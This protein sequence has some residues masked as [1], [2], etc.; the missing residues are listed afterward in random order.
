MMAQHEYRS[1]SHCERAGLGG[2]ILIG[3]NGMDL[4]DGQDGKGDAASGSCEI[5]VHV[6]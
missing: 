3:G 1:L 5:A 2:D 4:C 6:P